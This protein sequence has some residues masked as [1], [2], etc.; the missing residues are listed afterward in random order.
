MP[1]PEKF[2]QWCIVEL[3]GHNRI[4]GRVT[5]QTLGGETFIRVDVPETPDTPA[6]T[7]L[8]G[9]GAIYAINP[10]SEEIARVAAGHCC[11]TPVNEYSL[12]QALLPTQQQEPAEDAHDEDDDSGEP[13]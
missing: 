11:A 3:F 7:R 9:K 13:F 1:E 8:F 5:E 6:F 2:D 10:V 12:R 4:C